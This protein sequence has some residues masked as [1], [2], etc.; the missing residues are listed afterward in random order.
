MVH[1]DKKQGLLR[2]R[3]P[4][5]G[6]RSDLQHRQGAGLHRHAEEKSDPKD[7]R[8]A[9]GKK[10]ALCPRELKREDLGISPDLAERILEQI[11][12]RAAFARDM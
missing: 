10:A 12:G 1:A 7:D 11:I 6:D 9:S 3:C 4:R 5:S 2:S 8:A